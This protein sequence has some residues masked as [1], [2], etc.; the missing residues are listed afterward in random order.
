MMQKKHLFHAATNDVIS[1]NG[2][3]QGGDKF[4]Y[5]E[6]TAL[7]TCR[8]YGTRCFNRLQLI[9]YTIC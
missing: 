8:V 4:S 6:I 9:G 3:T 7:A 1:L 2:G 5:L